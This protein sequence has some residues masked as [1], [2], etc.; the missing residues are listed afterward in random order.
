MSREQRRKVAEET[1][2]ICRQGSYQD[3]DLAPLLDAAVEG[4]LMYEDPAAGPLGFPEETDAAVD[5]CPVDFCAMTTLD[6][7]LA[8]RDV[9]VAVL[10]FASAKN[11]GGGFLRGSMAQEESL[12]VAG[13][14]Y[15]C[16][17][18]FNA[19]YTSPKRNPRNGLYTHACIFSPKVPF[20]RDGRGLLLD[21][22]VVAS[23]LTCAAVNAGVVPHDLRNQ[24]IPEMRDRFDHV[25][26]VA[27]HHRVHRA[28]LTTWGVYVAML[29]G[30]FSAVS[31][32]CFCN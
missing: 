10:N 28:V 17:E 18:Q 7:I 25:L 19:H 20:F 11:P 12:A 9:D 13:G 5:P 21:E 22:P 6:A 29:E 2:A 3:V 24:I 4:S 30:S 31:K 26:R 27:A 14:L 15:V 32:P 8:H 1:L 23:V 16:L